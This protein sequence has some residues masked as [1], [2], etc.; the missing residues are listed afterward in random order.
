MKVDFAGAVGADQAVAIA[1]A[2]LDRDVFKK[3]LDP[4]LHGDV[5]GDEH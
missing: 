1:L 5:V 4:E 3:G 2:E